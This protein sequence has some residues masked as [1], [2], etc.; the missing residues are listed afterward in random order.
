[1]Q[2]DDFW[3]AGQVDRYFPLLLRCPLWAWRGSNP[4]LRKSTCGPG[5]NG[6]GNAAEAIQAAM[7]EFATN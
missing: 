1:M 6:T 3:L 4:G 5:T 2:E 7:L